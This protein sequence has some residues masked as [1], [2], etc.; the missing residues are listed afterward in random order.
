MGRLGIKPN[1]DNNPNVAALHQDIQELNGIDFSVSRFPNGEWMAKS[2]NIDG[3]LTGG[4]ATDSVDEMI[5]DAVLTYYNIAPAYCD[6]VKVYSSN[7]KE[8]V[9]QEVVVT[10]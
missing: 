9:Q 5:K 7:N 1:P 4:D 8:V 3:I 10:A 6:A 2:T